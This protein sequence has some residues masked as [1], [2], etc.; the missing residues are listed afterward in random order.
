MPPPPQ[1]EAKHPGKK[2]NM[3]SIV[4]TD[5]Q[6]TCSVEWVHAHLYCIFNI[7]LLC[8]TLVSAKLHIRELI[9]TN[10]HVHNCINMHSNTVCV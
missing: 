9:E 5:L 4:K 8:S 6:T 7:L 3:Q 2:R 10:V 1:S